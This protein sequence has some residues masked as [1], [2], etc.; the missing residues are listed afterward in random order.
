MSSMTSDTDVGPSYTCRSWTMFGWRSG[1]IISTSS[2]RAVEKGEEEEE[3]A[4]R[5]GQKRSKISSDARADE[6]SPT[7]PH[8]SPH[9]R[10]QSNQPLP[11]PPPPPNAA[12][13]AARNAGASHSRSVRSAQTARARG[14]RTRRVLGAERGLGDDLHRPGA[15]VSAVHAAPHGGEAARPQQRA[16]GVR[17]LA[18]VGDAGAAH[19]S[20]Q[21]RKEREREGREKGT[22]KAAE[23]QLRASW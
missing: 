20:S 3:E 13:A 15:T 12:R 9:S 10:S 5:G 4:A 11:P 23:T 6:W 16:E 21:T 17:R 19:G 7:R 1:N 14:Q 22:E 18:L 2:F 8:A